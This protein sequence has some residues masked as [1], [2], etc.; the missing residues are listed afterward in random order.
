MTDWSWSASLSEGGCQ[1]SQA[2]S[3]VGLGHLDSARFRL[4]GGQPDDRR[5]LLSCGPQHL[6]LTR[7]Q[8]PKARLQI[9]LAGSGWS[10]LSPPSPFAQQEPQPAGDPLPSSRPSA[11]RRRP[12]PGSELTATTRRPRAT[13]TTVGARTASTCVLASK[14][15]GHERIGCCVGLGTGWQERRRDD[16]CTVGRP[17]WPSARE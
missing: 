3:A 16:P 7:P 15:N 10:L 1:R 6:A 12:A 4:G 9:D 14:P 8:S 17:V 2:G 5:G 13:S 11:S